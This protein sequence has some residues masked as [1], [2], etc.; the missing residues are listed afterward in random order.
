MFYT[1]PLSIGV[2]MQLDRM[3]LYLQFDTFINKGVA[4]LIKLTF[5][6]SFKPL[7]VVAPMSQKYC[8]FEASIDQTTFK[9]TF[10]P[11]LKLNAHT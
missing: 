3:L 8:W 10:E 7:K 5:K 1:L 4:T 6:P 9:P 2:C 11:P